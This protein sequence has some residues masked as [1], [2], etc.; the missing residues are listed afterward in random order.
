M[1]SKVISIYQSVGPWG[2]FKVGLRALYTRLLQ[3][4]AALFRKLGITFPGLAC[5]ILSFQSPD[6]GSQEFFRWWVPQILKSKQTFI[7]VV[8]NYLGPAFKNLKGFV[9]SGSTFLTYREADSN[10]GQADWIVIQRAMLGLV[11]QHIYPIFSWY[12]AVYSNDVF[13]LLAKNT[14]LPEVLDTEKRKELFSR[15]QSLATS[16]DI[17]VVEKYGF[18]YMIRLKTM[19]AS[20]VDEVKAEYFDWFWPEMK[21]FKTVLDIGS[22]IGSF[23]TQVTSFLQPGGKV[24]AFEPEPEN[25]KLLTE[26]VRLNQ[27][28]AEI[29]AYN[30]AI[31][32]KKGE[33]TLFVSSD[34]TG[35]NKL[36]VPETSSHS[37][38]TVPTIDIVSFIDQDSG[39]IDLLKIDVEGW[40]LPIL[41]HLRPRL[42]QV[43]FLIGELQR[44]EFGMPTEAIKLLTEEGF[45]VETKGD[46][47]LLLFRARRKS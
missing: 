4:V 36:G 24:Y 9:T 15:V 3:R 10:A 40:E 33:A 43:K 32:D 45:E 42:A 31:S 7:A 23:A 16:E 17:G 12:R 29:N 1:K 37:S 46:P 30:A 19:D 22:Q 26:N 13:V 11:A 2:F 44:S 8:P 21:N 18:Q 35:G 28:D 25:F 38:V 47:Y 41:R 6:K 27:L 5:Q 39:P 34:N 14:T 20:I